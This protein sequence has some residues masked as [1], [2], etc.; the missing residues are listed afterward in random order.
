MKDN[1][2]KKSATNSALKSAKNSNLLL[3]V[4]KIVPK[5][6]LKI[7][8]SYQKCTKKCQKKCPKKVPQKKCKKKCTKKCQK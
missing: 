1:M 4:P 2:D 5:K 7:V 8:S 6:G 3:K